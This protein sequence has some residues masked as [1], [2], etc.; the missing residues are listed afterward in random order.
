[1]SRGRN[2][3]SGPPTGSLRTPGA[4]GSRQGPRIGLPQDDGGVGAATGT[5]FSQQERRE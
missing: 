5:L 1:M 4:F 3:R 2:V